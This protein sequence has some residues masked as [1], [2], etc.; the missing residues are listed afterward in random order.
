MDDGG[1]ASTPR[2]CCPVPCLP[3]SS[4]S[5]RCCCCCAQAGVGI[6]DKE[7]LESAVRDFSKVMG[8]GGR[9]DGLWGPSPSSLP[10]HP[11]AI[12]LGDKDCAG[13]LKAAKA[14]LKK[15]RRK[16]YYQVRQQQPVGGERR[17]RQGSAEEEGRRALS[18]WCIGEDRR[19][20]YFLP[21]PPHHR[22]PLPDPRPVQ[23]VRRRGRRRASQGIPQGEACA[24]DL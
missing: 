12:E 3:S 5:S 6:G 7:S 20:S 23:P 21:S 22:P 9:A 19:L 10:L 8:G 17:G 1:A 18:L 13:P 14:A 4:S 16:D 11:Q 24:A 15:A 2:C